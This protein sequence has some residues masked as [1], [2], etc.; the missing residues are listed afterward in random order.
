MVSKNNTLLYAVLLFIAE[1]F[2]ESIEGTQNYPLLLL[3]L[4]SKEGVPLH[5]RV[6]AG[7]TLKNY[8]KR[9]W[10]VVSFEVYVVNSFLDITVL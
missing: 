5:L 1:K 4:I 3:A 8:V 7:I 6:S 2:L 10:R 9:N